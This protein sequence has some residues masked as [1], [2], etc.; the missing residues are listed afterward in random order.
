MYNKEFYETF[1]KT[2]DMIAT[3]SIEWKR[4]KDERSFL[5]DAITTARYFFGRRVNSAN[6]MLSS[7]G[8]NISAYNIFR[9]N[10]VTV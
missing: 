10:K 7:I 4:V 6:T 2:M 9:E 5:L 1:Q 8:A 3:Q